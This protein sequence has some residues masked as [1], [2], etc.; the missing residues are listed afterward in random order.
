MSISKKIHIVAHISSLKSMGISASSITMTTASSSSFQSSV[1]QYGAYEAVLMVNDESS[2]SLA[3]AEDQDE[4]A[5]VA[6]SSFEHDPCETSS[7]NDE[8]VLDVPH[9]QQAQAKEDG[10]KSSVPF[11][12]ICM[13]TIGRFLVAGCF[14]GA[15][16]AVLGY[17]GLIDLSSRRRPTKARLLAAASFWSGMTMT[18]SY[19]VYALMEAARSRSLQRKARKNHGDIM[20]AN[21]FASGMFLGFCLGSLVTDMVY[22][23]SWASVLCTVGTASI[24]TVLMLFY[25]FVVSEGCSKATIPRSTVVAV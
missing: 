18:V 13:S 12:G 24:W 25:A 22:G 19:V 3:K 23:L 20:H 9:L 7:V 1:A 15:L 10:R 17:Q 6:L 2:K 4:H 14:V 21:S 16:A 11:N 8:H 5:Y